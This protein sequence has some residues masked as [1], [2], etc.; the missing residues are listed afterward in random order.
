MSAL[1]R[2]LSKW[3]AAETDAKASSGLMQQKLFDHLVGTAE[4]RLRDSKTERL[5]RLEVDD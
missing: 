2:L 5:G 1:L 3:C 4:D